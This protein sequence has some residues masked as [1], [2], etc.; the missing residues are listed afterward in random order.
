VRGGPKNGGDALALSTDHK[1]DDP[2]ERERILK[3]GGTVEK[4]R[5]NGKLAVSRALGDFDFK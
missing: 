3:A 4:S 2:L 5:V 1:P